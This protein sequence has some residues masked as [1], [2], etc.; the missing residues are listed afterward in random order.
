MEARKKVEDRLKVMKEKEAV[1]NYVGK[2]KF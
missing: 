1:D 2:A